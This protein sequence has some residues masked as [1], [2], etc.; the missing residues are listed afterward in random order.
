[1]RRRYARVGT[2]RESNETFFV[3]RV[4]ARVPPT[5]SSKLTVSNSAR[6]PAADALLA[7]V[8]NEW[9]EMNTVN[10]ATAWHR[11]AKLSK[12]K[13]KRKR[14][15]SRFDARSDAR[16]QILERLA[17]Q[18]VDAFDAMNLAN[19]VWSL[20]VLD[21]HAFNSSQRFLRR[22][23]E[24]IESAARRGMAMPKYPPATDKTFPS[25]Q[26]VSN[27]L[28]A[29]TTMKHPLAHALAS[30]LVEITP[31]FIKEFDPETEAETR[32][33]KT[34]DDRRLGT[35]AATETLSPKKK[36]KPAAPLWRRPS[37]TSSGVS[38]RCAG[39]PGTRTWTRSRARSRN[40]SHTSS[41]RS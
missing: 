28:W 21:H 22:A 23:C 25:A 39:T 14:G 16:M 18:N 17:F 33:D 38:G 5:R 29:F 30:L 1:M 27:C 19:V 10:V 3:F 36:K 15:A 12:Q 24:R 26:A 41:R 32:T 11:L 31:K 13:Q 34:C 8:A 2:S 7:I 20:A 40:T 6:R 35:A 37:R 9:R 4:I